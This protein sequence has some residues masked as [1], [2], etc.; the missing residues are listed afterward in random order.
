MG[1][2]MFVRLVSG[3]IH[4]CVPPQPHNKGPAP[5]PVN[6]PTY[7]ETGVHTGL[8]NFSDGVSVFACWPVGQVG[9]GRYSYAILHTLNQSNKV[10]QGQNVDIFC[11]L[12]SPTCC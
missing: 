2:G 11:G 10:K 8:R 3:N 12:F 1:S 5:E 7:T 4:K 6:K 9:D